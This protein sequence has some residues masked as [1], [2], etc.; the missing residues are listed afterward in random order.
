[1]SEGTGQ[2][3]DMRSFQRRLILRGTLTLRTG[4]RVGAVRDPLLES[5]SCR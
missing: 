1:M 4:L 3:P 5:L 2:N